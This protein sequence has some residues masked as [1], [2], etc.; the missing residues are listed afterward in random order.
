MDQTNIIFFSVV[1][2][3]QVVIIAVMFWMNKSSQD[4]KE[5][6]QAQ[7]LREEEQLKLQVELFEKLRNDVSQSIANNGQLTIDSMVKNN[8]LLSKN[9]GDLRESVVERLLESR[10]S[11]NKDIFSFKDLLSKDMAEKFDKLSLTVEGRLDN[12]NKQVQ[13]NLNEGFKKTNETFTGIITRLAKID[14]AQKKIDSLSTNVM[15]LQ[16]VLTDKKSR[17]IFGEVQLNNVLASVFGEGGKY[18]SLQHKLS[19]GKLVDAALMLPE[20]VGL[21]CVDSKFPLENFKRMFEGDENSKVLARKEFSKNIK[22]HIDDISSKYIIKDQTSDQ[23]IMFLPAEAIFAELH[24]YHPDIIDYAQKKRVWITGPS[25]LMATLMTVQTV[26][27]NMERSKYMSILH[28]EINKLGV[29]FN[30]YEERWN[31]LVKHLGTVT[32]D[33]D[34]IHVTT[35]K[36]S[37]QFQRIMEV[38]VEEEQ[39]P[40]ITINKSLSMN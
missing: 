13:Q 21:L 16:D 25:T 30:R 24:A 32:K 2:I 14:E 22:K 29:E 36:I 39:T 33:A 1:I 12:I 31:D 28:K 20:P 37:K 18:Y 40:E 4:M 19:N 7:L 34:K 3:L 23:A 11:L 9:F 6:E 26:V 5:L 15:S 8:D 35:G 17:G 10:N 27:M 38:E